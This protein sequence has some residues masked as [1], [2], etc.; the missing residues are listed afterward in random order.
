MMPTQTEVSSTMEGNYYDI[1][2]VVNV[3]TKEA[4]K[5]KRLTN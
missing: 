1:E 2:Y 5:E 4:P 3:I